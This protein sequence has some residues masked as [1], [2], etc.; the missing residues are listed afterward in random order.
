MPGQYTPL[1]YHSITRH[2]VQKKE[3]FNACTYNKE[4]HH[5]LTE[6]ANKIKHLISI[7]VN[8]TM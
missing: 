1:L 7:S 5:N 4:L 6:Q 8:K 2:S 3:I